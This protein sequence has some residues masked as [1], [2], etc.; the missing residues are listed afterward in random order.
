MDR[1]CCNCGCF[2]LQGAVLGGKMNQSTITSMNRIAWSIRQPWSFRVF[3]TLAAAV[4]SSC[5][6]CNTSS[7]TFVQIP[8]LHLFDEGKPRKANSP[9]AHQLWKED[10][11]AFDW[12]IG[13]IKRIKGL[14]FVVFTGDLGL[15]M[16]GPY[17]ERQAV[18]YFAKKLSGLPVRHIL[19]VPGNNDLLN[20][21]PRDIGRY[22]HFVSELGKRLHQKVVDLSKT[23]LE[24]DGM[25]LH[26]LDS[27]TFKNSI[28]CRLDFPPLGQRALR[29]WTF[30]PS[31][32]SFAKPPPANL[33]P[34]Q[35]LWCKN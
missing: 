17:W 18:D 6:Q 27:A 11:R 28:P 31:P 33:S 2:L 12:T 10:E 23:S 14:K 29:G 34:P 3:L 16:T 32:P 19:F 15:E 35:F 4:L 13:R 9:P 20:E 30:I 7:A 22:Q 1:T 25:S 5:C 21:E 8:D 26:G 24:I